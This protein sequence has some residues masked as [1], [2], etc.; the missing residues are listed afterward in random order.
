MF[1][2]KEQACN[3]A[4]HTK[5]LIYSHWCILTHIVQYVTVS[6]LKENMSL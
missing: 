2:I 5:K 3:Q 1:Y 6:F 4:A